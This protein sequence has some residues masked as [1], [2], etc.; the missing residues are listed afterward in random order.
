MKIELQPTRNAFLDWIYASGLVQA[1]EFSAHCADKLYFARLVAREAPEAAQ[2]FLPHS[3]GVA[4]FLELGFPLASYVVKAAGGMDSKGQLFT[5]EQFLAALKENRDPFL[6]LSVVNELTGLLSSGERYLVQERLS[7]EEYRLHSF[8]H[9]VVRGATYTRWDSAWDAE[10]FRQ[11]EDALEQFLASLPLELTRA[12]AW[13]VD[14]IGG[15]EQGF[16]L[17][18]VNTNRGHKQHWSGDLSIPDTLAAYVRHLE[19]YY[20]IEFT[21]QGGELLRSG[22]ANQEKYVAKFGPA[23]VARHEA[24]RASLKSL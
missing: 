5:E 9:R 13:S 23:A 3:Y 15:V 12:Q 4:E 19:L 22:K 24:L 20:G 16:R 7:G 6:E 8:E 17:V 14:L 1:S 10:A 11:A 2:K 21:G 18:E